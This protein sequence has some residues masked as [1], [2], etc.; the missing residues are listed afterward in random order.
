M[1]VID[2]AVMA[3]THDGLERAQRVVSVTAAQAGE[4]LEIII[5]DNGCGMD[6][7]TASRALEPLFSTAASA[8][9]SACRS[10]NRR[11]RA[12]AAA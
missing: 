11:F 8:S 12:M 3:V 6:E 7:A 10:P 9:G 2:N 1:K 4:R 5:A